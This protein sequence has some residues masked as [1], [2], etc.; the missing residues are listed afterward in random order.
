MKLIN[1]RNTATALEPVSLDFLNSAPVRVQR[2]MI[3][4][5]TSAELFSLVARDP[6]SWGRW[7]PGFTTASAWLSAEPHGVGSRRKMRAFGRDFDETILAW[8]PN[9]RFA[10]RVDRGTG[11]TTRG[12]VEDWWLDAVDGDKHATYATWAMAMDTAL[13]SA[14]MRLQMS[15][16]Q[17]VMM[18][19]ARGRIEQITRAADP[20]PR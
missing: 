6:S 5:C 15:V 7:C 8:E 9:K 16:Q 3:V 12:F 4:R 2:S 20:R 19:L 17:T 1:R 10:F 11:A 13:P 18:R 14:L